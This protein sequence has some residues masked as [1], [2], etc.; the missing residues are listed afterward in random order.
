MRKIIPINWNTSIDQL[1]F[2]VWD[3]LNGNFWLPEKI[4]LSNDVKSWQTLTA[5]EKLATKKVFAGLTLLDT[6]QNTIGAPVIAQHALTPHEESVMYQI[7]Y[8]EGVHAKSYSSIFSTLCSTEEINEI[9]RWAEEDEL[10]QTKANIIIDAYE[11]AD[12]GVEKALI[13]RAASVL[14][15]SF[16]F[17]SGFYLPFWFSSRGKLTNTADII[18]LILRDE[19]VH[20]FYIGY[21]F[22]QT[23]KTLDPAKRSLVVG[24][25]ENLA[26]RLY[27]LECQ[28]A[29]QIYDDLGWTENVKVYLR[30]NMNKAL[31]NLGMDTIFRDNETRVEASILSSMTVDADENH[32]FFSGSGSSYVIGDVEA[33][34][35]DDWS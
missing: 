13:A 26:L 12:Q 35:D 27:K 2:E 5:D 3:R 19:G 25:I 21:K 14:L 30:Y 8:M 10:L 34:T 22:Q 32:D 33:T 7:A 11:N 24:T 4:P 23:L 6:V 29:E 16:L 20:G 1:D 18:R 28:Y 31:Q 9:F 17:Y 15:E